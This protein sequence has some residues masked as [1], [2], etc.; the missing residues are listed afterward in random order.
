MNTTAT[1]QG[2]VDNGPTAFVTEE[3]IIVGLA[4]GNSN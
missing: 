2:L 4:T 3:V 1:T